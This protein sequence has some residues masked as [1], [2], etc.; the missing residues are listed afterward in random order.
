[1]KKFQEIDLKLL[2]ENAFKLI[3]QDWMLITAGNRENLNTMTASWG[4]LGVLWNK[5]I[6]FTFIR[7]QRYTFE[8]VEKNDYFSLS[9]FSTKYRKELTFCGTNS[10][11]DLNKIEKINFIPCFDELAPYFDEAKLTLICRKI[12]SDFIKPELFIDQTLDA[13]YEKKDYHKMYIGEIVKAL[14]SVE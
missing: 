8:F 11:R 14:V 5:N 3:G 10:G 1:M 6:A 2:N 13:N 7:P 9:F 4:G 12:Y